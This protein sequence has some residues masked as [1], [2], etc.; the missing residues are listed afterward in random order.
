M[1]ST[2]IT[3]ASEVFLES[4][5]DFEEILHSFEI[6]GNNEHILEEIRSE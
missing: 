4:D 1:I 6:G 5:D 2:K 3:E